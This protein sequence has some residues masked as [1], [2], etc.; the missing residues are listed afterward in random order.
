MTLN[1]DHTR[2]DT[3][4]CKSCRNWSH[5][6][7]MPCAMQPLGPTDGHCPDWE[8]VGPDTPPTAKLLPRQSVEPLD[9]AMETLPRPTPRALRVLQELIFF[10]VTP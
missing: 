2:S 1:L 9:E 7:W 5:T 10:L 8:Q 6:P 4:L 3:H